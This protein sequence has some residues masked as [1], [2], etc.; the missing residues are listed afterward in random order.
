MIVSHGCNCSK[1]NLWI[2]SHN[3]PYQKMH[4][5]MIFSVYMYEGY[6]HDIAFLA[7]KQRYRC[8]QKLQLK[9]TFP[10]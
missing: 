3:D 2:K 10:A 9:V 8:P 7:K 5:N 6:K 1:E 4:R